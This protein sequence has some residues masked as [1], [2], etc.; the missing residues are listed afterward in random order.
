MNS[1]RSDVVC[2]D[3]RPNGQAH[4]EAFYPELS[5]STG[6]KDIQVQP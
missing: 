4:F 3:K 1:P 6:L 2:P 5:Q